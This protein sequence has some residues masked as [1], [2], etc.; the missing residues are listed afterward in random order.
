MIIRPNVPNLRWKEPE[1]LTSQGPEPKEGPESSGWHF[2]PCPL[3][4]GRP[5]AHVIY[6]IFKYKAGL[7]IVTDSSALR[8]TSRAIK[9]FFSFFWHYWDLN[10]HLNSHHFSCL[11]PETSLLNAFATAAF[12]RRTG[13]RKKSSSRGNARMSRRAPHSHQCPFKPL[14]PKPL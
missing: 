4:L 6:K 14:S 11:Q 8:S 7:L 12:T 1:R 9:A 5:R 13:S 2:L 10:S 3:W